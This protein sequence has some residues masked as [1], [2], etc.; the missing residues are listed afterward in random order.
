MNIYIKQVLVILFLTVIIL[1]PLQYTY[2]DTQSEETNTQLINEMQDYLELWDTGSLL[3]NSGSNLIETNSK[4]IELWLTW[5]IL[6]NWNNT[7]TWK[8]IQTKKEENIVRN[9][10][11]SI[12]REKTEVIWTYYLW[13]KSYPIYSL[14]QWKYDIMENFWLTDAQKIHY[15][16]INSLECGREDWFCKSQF[17]SWYFQINKIHK[18]EYNKSN[19]LINENKSKELFTFQLKWTHDRLQSYINRICSKWTNGNINTIFSCM[20]KVHN[21]NNKIIG[22]WWYRFKDYYATKWLA[23]KQALLKMLTYSI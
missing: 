10:L 14:A 9:G 18:E 1:Q 15:L 21:G 13:K 7:D 20:L 19:K 5:T 16:V 4:T 22:P 3:N 8:I 12:I 11:S 17:D 2:A 23:L 6:N